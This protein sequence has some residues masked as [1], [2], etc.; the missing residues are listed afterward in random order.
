MVTLKE[1]ADK[2]GVSIATVSNILNG[3]SN[4][5]EETREKILQVIKETGYRPNYMA[6]TLRAHK[7]NTIGLIVDDITDFSTPNL[8]DGLMSLCEKKGYKIILENIRFYSKKR[9]EWKSDDDFKEAVEMAIQE[10]LAIKV[11]GIIYVASHSRNIDCFPLNLDIPFV[12]SYAYS[13]EPIPTVIFD[14]ESAA[15]DMTKYL[16]SKGHKKI[17]LVMGQEQS[18]HTQRRFKGFERAMKES[19]LTLNEKL[20]EYGDWKVESGFEACSKIIESKE[21]FTAVF[22]FNDL[23]ALGVYD[24]LRANKLEP[25]EDISVAGFDNRTISEYVS[26]KLTT[27][28]IPLR[29]LGE[30]SADAL[31]E[32]INGNELETN[33]MELK[34]SFVERESVKKI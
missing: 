5:S 6:R 31:I 17:A 13:D 7:T 11:D 32:L 15:Y 1:I 4:F 20:F 24:C 18:I 27:M 19:N 23:M 3:K 30:K 8:I 33:H 21:E 28:E 9:D 16:I 2:C 10:M 12:I 14:D 22:C 26:P 34:C 29:D 25:G